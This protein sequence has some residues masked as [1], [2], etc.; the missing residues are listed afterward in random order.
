[1][2][3]SA[4]ERRDYALRDGQ[5]SALHFGRISNPIKLVFC[6][7]NGFNALSYRAVLAPLGVHAIAIDMRGHGFSKLPADPDKLE[8]WTIFR[9]DITEFVEQYVQGPTMLAGHS[10]G[11]VSAILAAEKIG[12]RCTG[13]VGFDPVMV[14]QPFRALSASA[15]GRAMMKKRIPI[16]AKAGRRRA[17]F[18]SK[19]AAF[20]NYKNRGAFKIIRDDILRDYIEGGM[21]VT[22]SGVRLS[23]DPLWEQAIFVAQNQNAAKAAQ[24]LPRHRKIIFAG[25]NSPTPFSMQARMRVRLGKNNV[26]SSGKLAHLFPLQHPELAVKTLADMLKATALS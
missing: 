7:A 9:D 10:F 17:E 24:K 12:P 15:R 13:F 21:V 6:H 22:P 16:A 4:P 5:I 3:Y 25:K 19:T 26:T 20:E 18:E 11:A 8:N 23:C 14:P 2:E 1:M